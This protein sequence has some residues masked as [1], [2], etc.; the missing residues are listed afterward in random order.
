MPFISVEDLKIYFSG[1]PRM[2]GRK[3]KLTEFVHAVDG[4]SFDIREGEILSLVGESGCGKTTTGMGVLRLVDIHEGKI[5]FRDAN[6]LAMNDRELRQYRRKAQ[7]IFQATVSSLDPRMTVREIV[8]EP[9]RIHDIEKDED[10]INDLILDVFDF[11]GLKKGDLD[12]FPHEFSGGQARRIGVARALVLRPDFIVA[13]EPTSGLDVSVAAGI[14]NL[15]RD[16]RDKFQLTYLWISHNLHAVSFISDRIAVMY[17]GQIV[18]I[19]KT[20]QLIKELYHPY[21]KALFSAVPMVNADARVER[22]LLKGDIPS[23][24]NPP[25]GCRFHTRCNRRMPI[26]SEIEPSLVEKDTD[27]LVRCHLYD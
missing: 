3:K 6:V 24:I 13:D 23:A 12:K 19:A 20:K 25:S 18:E 1:S 21:S 15:M 16:L 26:C 2:F 4:V 11:M 22:I 9:L 14:L 27:H 8:S 7:M 5:A 17:L 10:R